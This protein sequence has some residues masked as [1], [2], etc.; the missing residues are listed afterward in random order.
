MHGVRLKTTLTG[1]TSGIL[2]TI[3]HTLV[4]F[5]WFRFLPRREQYPLP[6]REITTQAL[7]RAGW[8]HCLNETGQRRATWAGHFAYGALAGM[9][10]APFV[11]RQQHRAIASGGLYGVAVWAASYQGWIPMLGL[12][13]PASK[14][15]PGRNAMMIAAHLAWGS[16]TG[17]AACVLKKH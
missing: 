7:H 2:G 16:V 17:L 5:T 9:L 6:P 4:M 8:A 1:A 14:Q 13:K 10:F 11:P 15:P 3:A 12:L